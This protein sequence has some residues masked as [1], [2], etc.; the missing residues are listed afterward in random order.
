L[1]VYGPPEG[2]LN[3]GDV[4]RDVP[5]HVFR[6]HSPELVAAPGLVISHSCDIDKFDE[7]KAKLTGNGRKRWPIQMVPLMSTAA[8]D[9]AQIGDA[10][11]GRHRRFF[12]IPKEG[13]HQELL[14]DFWLA[15]PVPLVIVQTL[16][17]LGTLSDEYLAKLWTH[18]FVSISRKK[19]ADVFEGGR[20]AS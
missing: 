16:T 12:Y 1:P 13:R 14:A 11:A 20:L 2:G 5:F 7:L 8:L 9:A 19:P 3:Q 10:K 4:I 15:Q 18:A 6:E 17:R